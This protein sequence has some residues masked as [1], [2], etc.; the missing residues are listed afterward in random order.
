VIIVQDADEGKTVLAELVGAARDVVIFTGAGISTE[1]GI[2]DFRS[3]NG[4]WSKVEPIWF[5]DFV[6]SER[7]RLEDWRRRFAFRDEF[8]VAEPNVAHLAIAR[9]VAA[10]KCRAVITQNI[11]GLH[12]RAGVPAEN[13]IE[14]HG[15]ATFATCLDCGRRHELADMEKA[16]AETGRSPRCTACGGLVKAAIVSFGQAMPAAEMRRAELAIETA[17]L[18]VAIGS[19]LQV[20]PAASLPVAAKYQ[21]ATL[22]IVNRD[23]TPLDELADRVLRGSIGTVFSAL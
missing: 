13:L 15:N 22:V 18:F 14:L 11:D 21:G 5:E 23:P 7:A 10:G 3:P 16:I 2:P 9:L 12:Q 8:T 19:S 17:D 1:S 6:A 20:Q 4:I